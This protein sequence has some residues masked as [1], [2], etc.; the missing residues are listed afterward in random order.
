MTQA[1]VV[2]LTSV[3]SAGVGIA[4]AGCH[5]REARQKR[6]SLL[7]CIMHRPKTSALGKYSLKFTVSSVL[8]LNSAAATTVV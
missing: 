5:S 1:S 4:D 2:C 7:V 3:R 8:N 6:A